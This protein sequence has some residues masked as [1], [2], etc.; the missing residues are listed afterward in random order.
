MKVKIILTPIIIV[1]G[2]VIGTIFTKQEQYYHPEF[3][4]SSS[5]VDFGISSAYAYP[6]A[7][8]I[9]SNSKNCLSCH[10][11][12]GLWK[13]DDN[14]I[15]DILDSD[16]KKSLKQTDGKFLIEVK[17]GGQ[18]TIITVL[19]SKKSKSIPIPHRN[20]WLYIDTSTI[21]TNSI[22]K[23]APNW[24]VN[25]QMACRLVGDKLEGYEDT[26]ITSLPMTLRPL[27]NAKDSE[28]NLQVMFTE[29]ESVKGNTK[30]GI[31]S[32]YFERAVKMKI[33]Q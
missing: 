22:S 6:P 25:L 21:G 32:N 29:G 31:K 3:K 23:F 18:K 10:V 4:E 9:L 7:V 12:N 14:T 2:I 11:N 27:E 17:K 28:I 1:L 33:I 16:S 5:S 15:I 19:G 30:A 20:A 8:G 13:D 26:D 24:E